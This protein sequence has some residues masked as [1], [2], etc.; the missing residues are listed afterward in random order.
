M[1]HVNAIRK[2]VDDGEFDQAH[3]AI[4]NLLALGPNNLE[5]LKLQAQIYAARGE[6]DLELQVWGRVLEI[7]REDADGINFLLQQ[8]IEDREHFYF[9]D[10]L[11]GGARRYLCYPRSFIHISLLGLI[12]CVCFFALRSLSVRYPVLSEQNVLLASFAALVL[13][14]WLG[15]IYVWIR[16]LKSVVVHK[17]GINL[18][19]R[20]GTKRYRWKEQSQVALVH[21]INDDHSSIHLVLVPADANAKAL[22]LNLTPGACSIKA[23][24][25]LMRDVAN[26]CVGFRRLEESEVDLA[27]YSVKTY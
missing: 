17:E 5:A 10:E 3:D 21:K 18:E 20:F 22:K 11:P 2:F 26:R 14:P 19:T 6:I 24:S 7:D 25:Y 4:E 9:T 27:K 12:G 8:Q 15:I 16:S 13:A 1:I 23:R